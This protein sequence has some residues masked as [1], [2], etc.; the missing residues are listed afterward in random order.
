MRR[1]RLLIIPLIMLFLLACGL[2]NGINQA[3][4][5]LPGLLTSAPTALGVVETAVASL[6]PT[7]SCSGTPTAGS[8]DVQLDTAKSVLQMTG[9]FTFTEGSQ[10]G[11]P[12]STAVLASTAAT[13]F[14][15]ISS[16]FAAQ[17]TGDP[18]NLSEIKVTIPRT[19]QQ[20]TV[21]QGIAATTALFSSVLPP[22]V[23]LG[24]F[25]WIAQNYSNLAVGSQQQTT[26]GKFQFTLQRDQN[27]MLVDVLP[28][29]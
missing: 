7:S 10:N 26:F 14:S 21:D 8:L 19:D 4:T 28:A 20:N 6:E 29:K 18:C 5:Q 24:L 25:T 3:V 16:G 27:N 13:T 15:A 22:Q 17:F 12:V 11:Q 23:T 2:A 9:Q 1:T